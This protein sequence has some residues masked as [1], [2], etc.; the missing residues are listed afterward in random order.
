MFFET[1]MEMP[2]GFPDIA[3]CT[4]RI[5]WTFPISLKKNAFKNS[6]HA[7]SLNQNDQEV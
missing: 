3:S 7:I 6:M 4:A 1:D 5:E 2:G